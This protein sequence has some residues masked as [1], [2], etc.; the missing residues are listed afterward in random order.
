MSNLELEQTSNNNNNNNKDNEHDY[1]EDNDKT[2]CHPQY[3]FCIIM[4]LITKHMDGNLD[5][6]FVNL[7]NDRIFG[8]LFTQN[9]I[10]A[11][12]IV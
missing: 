10:S 3:T 12:Y 5:K 2:K 8:R 4:K 1:D 6:H 11:T 7:A 9:I